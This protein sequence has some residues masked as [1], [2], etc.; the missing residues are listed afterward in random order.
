MKKAYVLFFSIFI[1]GILGVMINPLYVNADGIKTQTAYRIINVNSGKPIDV[2]NGSF[3]NGAEVQI[4]EEYYGN[5]NQMF[6]FSVNED[7]S[8]SIIAAHTLKAIEVRNSSLEDGA[9][10][11]QWSY[12]NIP[13]MKWNIFDNGDGTLSFRNCNSGKFLDVRGGKTSNGTRV[14]Q[15]MQ[16]NTASQKF[17]LA[18]VSLEELAYANRNSSNIVRPDVNKVYRI[19]NAYSGKVLDIKDM[20]YD[21]G[22]KAQLWDSYEGNTNQM[23]RFMKQG[24]GYYSMIVLFSNK[25]IEVGG[26]ST[27]PGATVNQWDHHDEYSPQMW[28]LISLGEG[29]FIIC[30]KNSGLVLDVFQGKFV[31]GQPIT[32]YVYNGTAAQ[33][34]CLEEVERKE[35]KSNDK[36]KTVE[37]K[38][39]DLKTWREQIEVIERGLLFNNEGIIQEKRILEWTNFDVSVPKYQGPN[40][41]Q[42]ITKTISVPSKI[43]YRIHYHYWNS[44]YGQRWRYGNNSIILMQSCDCGYQDSWAWEIPDFFDKSGVQDTQTTIRVLPRLTKMGNARFN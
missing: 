32:Q 38:C 14:Q 29:K 33:V 2:V 15:Y 9:P 3:E 7:N 8:I 21:N 10:V 42:Y 16:N 28:K 6:Y 24:D 18:E 36:Y 41:T 43:E 23:I 30:N 11:G 39:N 20:N 44:G 12:E 26:L 34:F 27:K 5:K 1:F 17:V 25:A 35:Y 22:A 37:I 40:I 4:Y 19:V 13:T 31:N